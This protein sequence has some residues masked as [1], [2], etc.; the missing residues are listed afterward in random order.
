M[1]VE[2]PFIRWLFVKHPL[3]FCRNGGFFY[4]ETG[5]GARVIVAAAVDNGANHLYYRAASTFV[6]SYRG[7]LPLGSV[8]RWGFRKDVIAWLNSVVY[9][10]FVRYSGQNIGRCWYVLDVP[11]PEFTGP[12]VEFFQ[13]MFCVFKLHAIII[14]V[15]F[16]PLFSVGDVMDTYSNTSLEF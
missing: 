5:R 11:G 6:A 2:E 9:H 8:F 15:F 4:M 3:K 16:S 1:A 14:S 10:S 12:T 7:I 13:F